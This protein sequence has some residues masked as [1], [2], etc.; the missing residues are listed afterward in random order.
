MSTSPCLVWI[1]S[2]S[3]LTSSSRTAL[4]FPSASICKV[5]SCSCLAINSSLA[6]TWSLAISR[7][8]LILFIF[9]FR[10]SMSC[11]SNLECVE[12][13]VFSRSNC[14]SLAWTSPV[15]LFTSSWDLTICAWSAS[16]SWVLCCCCSANSFSLKCKF[17]SAF[18]SDEPRLST[19]FFKSW[20]S[21]CSSSDCSE[22]WLF[23][24]F[25]C[26]SLVW[27]SSF[28]LLTLSSEADSCC[29]RSFVWWALSCSCFVSMTSW[30]WIC[31]SAFLRE[32]F[33]LSSWLFRPWISCSSNSDCRELSVF[34]TTSCSFL[35]CI[36]LF[37]FWTSSS[38]VAICCWST[39]L[40][41][42]FSCWVL[43]SRSCV[44]WISCSACL[45]DELRSST[46]TVKV[47]ILL[48]RISSSLDFSRS[49]LA[50]ISSLAWISFL[51]LLV[52]S[53]RIST[54]SLRPL[55]CWSLSA[56]RELAADNFVS[57][58]F[59]FSSDWWRRSSFSFLISFSFSTSCSQAAICC[60]SLVICS[61]FCCSTC[62]S[63]SLRSWISCWRTALC[64]VIS[65]CNLSK[66][67]SLAWIICSVWD[68][69]CFRRSFCWVISSWYSASCCVLAWISISAFFREQNVLSSSFFKPLISV[70]YISLWQF[71]KRRQWVTI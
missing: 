18:L 11:W 2:L 40:C 10:L 44:S 17:S 12:V 15:S 27:I 24:M 65:F 4:C 13:S 54:S 37:N 67:S 70:S 53:V 33:R 66:I 29:C 36:S 64:S 48:L 71:K 32:S 6:W 41:W 58:S 57:R 21:W 55:I 14:S 7:E 62:S 63:W 5:L 50:S 51:F 35:T 45:R 68:F 61:V 31:S 8:L 22:L 20:I 69:C 47:W 59:T 43:A 30:A 25:I 16:I 23:N 39:S 34:R 28:M 19:C 60:C 42:I 1:S 49:N 38:Q 3:R 9:S 26:S 52:S 46:W 56:K